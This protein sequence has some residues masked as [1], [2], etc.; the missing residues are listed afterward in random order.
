MTKLGIEPWILGLC[1]TAYPT[2]PNTPLRLPS[3]EMHAS[4]R[5]QA[6]EIAGYAVRGWHAAIRTALLARPQAAEWAA[7]GI[8][9]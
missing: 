3:I 2:E 7:L 9:R 1:G 6:G 5:T 4:I 8:M